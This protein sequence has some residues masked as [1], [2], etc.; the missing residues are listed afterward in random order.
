MVLNRALS[1]RCAVT[2][3]ATLLIAGPMLAVDEDGRSLSFVFRSWGTDAGLPQNTVN[4]IVQ[5]RDGY[6]WLGT[7][8]GLARFNG[9]AFS[10]KGLADGLPN[11]SIRTLFEDSQRS[12]W[13]GTQGGGL[14]RL[15]DGRIETFS[16]ANGLAGV[17][18]TSI[19][20]DSARRIWVGTSAG[21][22]L[23]QGVKFGPHPALAS[24]E[25]ARWP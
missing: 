7:Q 13:I 12:L 11:I 20:E 18:V 16:V 22:S 3:A 15:R 25:R 24:L 19:A 6:L 14:S 4:T 9:V 8:R 10:L 23:L 2:V 21:L 5:T 1:V 17:N